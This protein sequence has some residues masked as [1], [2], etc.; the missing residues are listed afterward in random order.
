MN[1]REIPL[2]FIIFN[3][4]DTTEIVFKKIKEYK[5]KKL[6]IISDGPRDNNT[7]DIENCKKTR[8]IV[9]DINWD[10]QIFKK[11]SDVNLGCGINISSGLDWVFNQEEMAII[12]EDDCLP[13]NGFFEYCAEL[14]IKYKN[15]PNIMHIGGT[16]WHP[17]YKHGNNDSQGQFHQ[18]PLNYY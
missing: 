15:E 1:K 16:N 3:R 13:A 10:C 11:Y 9:E 4:P 8:K 17:E 18:I 6:Y 7:K 14:L 12:L 2:V 5:P